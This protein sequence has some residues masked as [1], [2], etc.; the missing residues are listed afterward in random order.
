MTRAIKIFMWGFVACIFLTEIDFVQ[1]LLGE[2]LVLGVDTVLIG[3][4]VLSSAFNRVHGV[5][6][7]P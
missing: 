6:M 2:T 7:W 3:M 5:D 4:A 1:D